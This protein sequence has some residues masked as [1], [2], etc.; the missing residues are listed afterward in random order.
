M[1]EYSWVVTRASEWRSHDCYVAVFF[2]RYAQAT[3]GKATAVSILAVQTIF[4]RH[5]LRGIST[6]SEDSLRISSRPRTTQLT[7]SVCIQHIRMAIDFR[8]VNNISFAF[9]HCSFRKRRFLSVSSW[10]F[11]DDAWNLCYSHI[12]FDHTQIRPKRSDLCSDLCS[13]SAA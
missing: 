6:D 8:D 13:N 4:V 5:L 7:L 9:V 1:L 11:L 10:T 12:E 2:L 3:S